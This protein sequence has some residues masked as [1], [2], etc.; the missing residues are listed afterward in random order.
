MGAD[1]FPLIFDGWRYKTPFGLPN[2]FYAIFNL[3]VIGQTKRPSPSAITSTVYTNLGFITN[4]ETPVS[5]FNIFLKSEELP[6]AE[7]SG[8][9]DKPCESIRSSTV[10]K[11]FHLYSLLPTYCSTS[12]F[13]IRIFLL[14]KRF[15][16]GIRKRNNNLNTKLFIATLRISMKLKLHDRIWFYSCPRIQHYFST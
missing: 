4:H 15:S 3:L 8:P 14:N 7:T 9:E 12:N 16:I 1:P 5:N 13:R 6:S 2:T 11:E 10:Y